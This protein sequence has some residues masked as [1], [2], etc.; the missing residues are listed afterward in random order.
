MVAHSEILLL[1]CAQFRQQGE[2]IDVHLKA[3]KEVF[4]AHRIVLAASSDYFHTM[5]A[6]GM[7][8]SN[9]E[10]IELK[11]E[12]IS[13]AALK[14]VLDSIYGGDLQVNDE[15]IFEVLVAADH[16]QVTSVVQ[17]CCEYL[18]TQFVQ[19]RFDVQT[20]CQ[21]C[22]IANRHGL[23]DLQEAAQSKMASMY[24]E[25][26]ESEEFLSHIDTDQFSNL[27]SRDDLSAPSETFV[28]KSVMQWVKYKKEERM[29]VAAK[30]IGSVRLGLVNIREVIRELNSEEMKQVPE[31]HTLLHESLLY[32]Y[33][34]SSSGFGEEKGKIRSSGSVRIYT[35]ICSFV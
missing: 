11:D 22:T 33:I 24:K 7:K 23:T 5:F 29:A 32:S 16:L 19:L 2:F 8:E 9:Q 27:L 20:Y 3:S 4:S 18:Q 28:F 15:N 21:I 6:H 26:C 30:V 12:S 25:V 17:Q 10:V 31:I 14:I 35:C 34:P 1:K 13:A